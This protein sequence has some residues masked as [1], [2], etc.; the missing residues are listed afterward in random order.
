MRTHVITIVAGL[1]VLAAGTCLAS[2]RSLSSED[3]LL[4]LAGL[5]SGPGLFNE[6][7]AQGPGGGF[8][9]GGGGRGRHGKD[10]EERW[11]HLEQ[12]RTLKMLEVLDLA[13]DQEVEFLIAFKALRKEFSRQRTE[14]EALIDSLSALLE[15]DEPDDDAILEL[16]DNALEAEKS[17]Q[18]AMTAFVGEVRDLLTPQQLGRFVVFA[19]RFERQLLEQ[20]KSFRDR[21]GPFP[22]MPEG[23]G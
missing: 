13:E 21:K 1:L 4:C 19:K 23:E 6:V 5:D 9:P 12:L 17:R 16:V 20:V 10:S 8:G 2:D 22:D 18:E 15:M 7:L 14:N 3:G 11:K